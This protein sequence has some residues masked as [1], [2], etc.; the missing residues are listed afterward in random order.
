M[1]AAGESSTP[2]KPVRPAARLR[3]L[4]LLLPLVVLVGPCVPGIIQTRREEPAIRARLTAFRDAVVRGKE[5][6]AL[7]F[8][9]RPKYGFDESLANDIRTSY[10]LMRTDHWRE[11]E[12]SV[13]FTGRRATIFIGVPP[14]GETFQ[15]HK[16]TDG[17]WYFTGESTI[18]YD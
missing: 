17:L 2:S 18:Y 3:W 15:L 5:E 4:W 14:G 16:E 12:I 6:E 11:A 10:W 8:I 13:S 7:A 9:R 1:S